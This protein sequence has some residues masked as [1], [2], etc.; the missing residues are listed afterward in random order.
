VGQSERQGEKLGVKT[1]V[2][3]QGLE[4]RNIIRS[5]LIFG[6]ILLVLL[7]SGLAHASALLVR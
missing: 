6:Y 4:Y 1:A 7:A 3:D 5:L 2:K